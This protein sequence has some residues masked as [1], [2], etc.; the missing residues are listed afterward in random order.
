MKLPG[1]IHTISIPIRFL[2]FFGRVFAELG[3]VFFGV[4]VGAGFA[5]ISPVFPCGASPDELLFAELPN[6][7][8]SDIPDS[9][10]TLIL[11]T[12]ILLIAHLIGSQR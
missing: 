7:E 6:R 4:G 9:I 5:M 1:G 3:G 10:A 11:K 2:I 12:S 8:S